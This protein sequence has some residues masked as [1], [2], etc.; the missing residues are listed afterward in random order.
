[1]RG[2]RGGEQGLVVAVDLDQLR[3]SET[4]R[5]TRVEAAGAAAPDH[6]DTSRTQSG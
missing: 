2:L 3:R 4:P 6:S 1:M 5:L